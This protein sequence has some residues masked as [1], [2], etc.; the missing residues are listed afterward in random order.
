MNQET[1][2]KVFVYGT[3]KPGESNYQYY[4]DGKSIAEIKA[5]T[6]GNLYNLSLGYPAMTEGKNKVLG[7]LLSFSS[8]EILK[9]LDRLEG[10]REGKPNEL[11]E[12]YRQEINVY[13]LSGKSLGVAWSYFMSETKI[14]QFNGVFLESGWWANRYSNRT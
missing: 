6:F 1:I 3:L 10:Y 4:C 7:Y 11:N 5:Y 14:R 9:S 8:A 12:Y 2:V 13:D